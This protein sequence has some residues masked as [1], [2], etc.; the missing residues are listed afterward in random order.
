MTYQARMRHPLK[1]QIIPSRPRPLLSIRPGAPGA[2][3]SLPSLCPHSQ[4]TAH[5]IRP[6][7]LNLPK[8]KLALKVILDD[9][10]H[11]DELV[12]GLLEG[13]CGRDGPVCL[14][15]KLEARLEWVWDFVAGELDRGVG[16]E[17]AREG[18][19]K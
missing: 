19:V 11:A 12:G 9:S 18:E 15:F 5:P 3:L 8:A 1:I 6:T 7:A 10:E 2:R 13:V 14:D 16:E 4:S 17:L